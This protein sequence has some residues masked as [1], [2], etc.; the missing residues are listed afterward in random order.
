MVDLTWEFIC[1]KFAAVGDQTVVSEWWGAPFLPRSK[2]L[3]FVCCDWILDPLDNLGH[4]HKVDFRMILKNLI[5]PIEEGIKKFRI[6][7]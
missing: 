6:I 2:V 5:H 1:I 4:C 3:G 7:F